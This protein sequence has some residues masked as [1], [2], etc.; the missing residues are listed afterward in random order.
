[1]RVES[2]CLTQN[3]SE[4]THREISRNKSE[5][6]SL[7]KEKEDSND[8]QHVSVN[9]DANSNT[10]QTLREDLKKFYMQKKHCDII[11]QVENKS[12]PAHR[13][14]LC[15][16]SSVFSS[17][18]DLDMKETTTKNIDIVDMDADTLGQFLLFLYSETPDDLQWNRA[19]RLLNASH[20]FQV[21]SLKK[22]CSSFL[23][24][25]LSLPNVC[26]ALVLAD[27][28]QDQQLRTKC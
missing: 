1:M 7:C 23:M 25:Y 3:Y 20:K 26:E 2:N 8:T 27:L 15:S 13:S 11:L 14:I 16:R 19:T 24:S 17:M 10:P 6:L 18:F 21:E 22:E 9:L 4:L 12:F 28:Y 5:E